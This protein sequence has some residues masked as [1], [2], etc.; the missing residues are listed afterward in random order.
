MMMPIWEA[1]TYEI[2]LGRLV[3]LYVDSDGNGQADSFVTAGGYSIDQGTNR[4]GYDFSYS[5]NTNGYRYAQF[6][7]V[8]EGIFHQ[9]AVEP[10]F[11]LASEIPHEFKRNH[12]SN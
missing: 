6:Q 3:V 1:F 2:K 5:Y 8:A 7:P 11:N 10:Y 9:I 4:Y 12:E